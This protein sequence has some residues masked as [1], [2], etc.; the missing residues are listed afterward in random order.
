MSIR[1][2]NNFLLNL[3]VEFQGK[4]KYAERTSYNRDTKKFIT[5]FHNPT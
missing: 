4:T 5:K 3:I 2:G 1:T